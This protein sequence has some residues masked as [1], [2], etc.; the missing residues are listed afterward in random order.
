MSRPPKKGKL[1][2]PGKHVAFD[3]LIRKALTESYELTPEREGV[4]R[5]DWVQG[6][7]RPQLKNSIQDVRWLPL[8]EEEALDGI[9]KH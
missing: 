2:D 1:L 4:A 7:T 3:R 8:R 9:R 6:G 5:G